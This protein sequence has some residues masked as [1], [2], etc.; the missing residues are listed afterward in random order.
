M[1]SSARWTV[2]DSVCL[3]SSVNVVA[4]N[5]DSERCAMNGGGTEAITSG[6][7]R[8]DKP[9]PYPFGEATSSHG[10]SY[11]DGSVQPESDGVLAMLGSRHHVGMLWVHFFVYVSIQT[12]LT[13]FLSLK[14]CILTSH[15]DTRAIET[16]ARHYSSSLC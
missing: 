1:T 15:Q 4:S 14:M 12:R 9:Q 13:W 10:N 8:L 16:V 6:A 5:S 3:S 11:G 2:A 7:M